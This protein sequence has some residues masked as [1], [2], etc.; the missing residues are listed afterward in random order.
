MLTRPARLAFAVCYR[1]TPFPHGD[2]FEPAL[3]QRM[4]EC[5]SSVGELVLPTALVV[6]ANS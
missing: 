3:L 5:L 4:A 1:A 2:A 6:Y